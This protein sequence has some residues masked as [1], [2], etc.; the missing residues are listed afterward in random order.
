MFYIVLWMYR[1]GLCCHMRS[2][3]VTNHLLSARNHTQVEG[4]LYYTS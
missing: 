3:E 4:V 1:A 2:K